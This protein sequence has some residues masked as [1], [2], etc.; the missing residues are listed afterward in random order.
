MLPMGRESLEWATTSLSSSSSA[1]SFSL[2][3]FLSFRI[4]LGRYVL[5]SYQQFTSPKPHTLVVIILLLLLLL[6]CLL[7]VPPKLSCPLGKSNSPSCHTGKRDHGQN[8]RIQLLVSLSLSLSSLA[9]KREGQTDKTR[10]DRISPPETMP[11]KSQPRL[12]P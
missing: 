8:I 10:Q 9:P 2:S 6:V 11:Q 7:Q 5:A 12:D 3:L 4:P 1:L